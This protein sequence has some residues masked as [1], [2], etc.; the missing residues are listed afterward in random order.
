MKILIN[1]EN[2]ELILKTIQATRS[3]R[4]KNHLIDWGWIDRAKADCEYQA[5]KLLK[6]HL[7]GFKYV[8][9]LNEKK[10]NSYKYSY[11]ADMITIEYS[12][13]GWILTS[14]SRQS[15]YPNQ[16][17][18]SHFGWSLPLEQLN[19]RR[20]EVSEYLLEGFLK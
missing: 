11:E 4:E 12:A 6:K 16:K 13:K 8:F 17:D 14:F 1:D 3:G 15:F 5:K 10:A 20:K 19:A 18:I 7:K 2:K 9:S